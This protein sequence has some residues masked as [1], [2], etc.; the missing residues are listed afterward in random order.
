MAY[1]KRSATAKRLFHIPD[2]FHRAHSAGATEVWPVA[3]QY[4]WRLGRILDP[5]GHYWKIGKPLPQGS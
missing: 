4:G 1:D 2:T 5:F 3:N